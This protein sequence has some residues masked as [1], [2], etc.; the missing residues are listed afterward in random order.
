MLGTGSAL[1][2]AF[3]GR[4]AVLEGNWQ[5][6]LALGGTGKDYA[7]SVGIDGAGNLVVAGQ[8]ERQAAFGTNVLTSR[9]GTDVFL[10][11]F[12]PGG[13]CLW[14]QPLDGDAANESAGAVVLD[15]GGTIGLTGALG[16][17]NAPPP[18]W[19]GRS[20]SAFL[21]R[22]ASDGARIG[23]DQFSGQG[24]S[25]G[26]GLAPDGNGGWF[27]AGRFSGTL[28]LGA[29]T[30][31]SAGAGDA[32]LARFDAAA[33]VVWTRRGGGGAWDGGQAVS[34]GSDGSVY[35]VGVLTPPATFDTIEVPAAG[36]GSGFLAK[37]DAAGTIQWVRSLGAMDAQFGGGT[38]F[39][40]VGDRQG[41][42]VLTGRGLMTGPWSGAYLARFDGS[43]GLTWLR[44]LEGA[45]GNGMAGLGLNGSGDI[46]AA[47]FFYGT[48]T[49]CGTPLYASGYNDLYIARF[50]AAGTLL[51]MRQAG[52]DAEYVIGQEGEWLAGLAVDAAGNCA[53][54]GYFRPNAAFDGL[55]LRSAGQEDG[56][57]ARFAVTPWIVSEPQSQRVLAGQDAVFGVVTSGPGPLAYQWFKEATPLAGA[58]QATLTL[59]AVA[60]A[61]AGR[62]RVEVRNTSGTATSRWAVLTVDTEGLAIGLHAVL[63]VAG[64]VGG[65]YAVQYAT[66][67][68]PDFW[69]TLTNLTLRVPVETWM[70][71]EPVRSPRRFYRSVRVGGE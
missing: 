8:F 21:A 46:Y 1:L 23:F 12:A 58:T 13:Q 2:V 20:M 26:V 69:T 9:N 56:F 30:L 44:G 36:Q 22:Y 17:T 29:V 24:E 10:A 16:D 42:A 48:A 31:T 59:K 43:G 65:N 68:A 70:D 41:G 6:A 33:R 57:L 63:S 7:S 18:P 34:V 32:F 28:R 19:G 40:V 14:V 71:P 60:P 49:L 35:L 50:D 11:R 62:Y 3:G 61:D 53:V 66:D 27:L 51:G 4:A 15:S 54:V 67:V 45:P 38:V 47:G 37:Y 39:A 64:E 52:G 25:A 55:A 5:S